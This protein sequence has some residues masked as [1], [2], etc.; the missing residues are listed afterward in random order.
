V[1]LRF[2]GTAASEGYPDA[3]C[4]CANCATAR[5]R[6]GRSLRRRS[7]AL[8]DDDLLIDLGPD[9]MAAALMDGF[10]LATIRYCLQTHEH[11]DHL[12]PAHF[13]SRCA[14]CS[15]HGNPRL[16]YYATQGALG[17][18]AAALGTRARHGLTDPETG[19]RLNLTAH[20]VAPFQSFTVGPYRVRTV[21]GA[22]DPTR[23]VAL[24]YV[25]ERDGRSLFYATDTG[26]LP[27]E[28]WADLAALR[29][30]GQR[31][32][33]VALDHTFGMQG[34]VE[35]HMNWEQ[36]IEQVARMRAE[37]LLADDARVFAHHLAHHSNPAHEEL[38]EFA[39]AR[40]YEVAWDGLVVDV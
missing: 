9:L 20:V 11:A 14:Y 5:E 1:R 28:T 40:G 30:A 25:I 12:D 27:A 34:R 16:Q 15:V 21:L 37:G 31:L 7:A 10:S 26:E 36:F 4:D 17:K 38:V 29:R 13:L 18:A 39:A 24:L 2:L 35:G 8:I 33:V 23:L 22:H 3:F 6:R 32:H 19:D